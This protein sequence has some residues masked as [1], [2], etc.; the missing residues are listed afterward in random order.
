VVLVCPLSALGLSDFLLGN[1]AAPPNE[2]FSEL[3]QCANVGI[4]NGLL[5]SV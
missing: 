5:G 2:N 4:G 1:L 3:L